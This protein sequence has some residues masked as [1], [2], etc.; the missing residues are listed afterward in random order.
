M[1]IKTANNIK[2]LQFNNLSKFKKI[3]HFSTTRIGGSSL[4]KLK[5]FNLGYTVND[6]PENVSKNLEQLAK[7]I[8]FGKKQMISPKQTHSA[9]IGIITSENDIFP[10]TDALITNIPNLCIYVRTADCVPVL[11][12]D[13]TRNV[14]S[15]IHSGWKGTI[16]E[17]SKRTIEI[18]RK[19]FGTNSKNIFA[20]IGPS[21][22]PKVYEVGP[23]VLEQFIKSF[24]NNFCTISIKGSEKGFLDLWKANKQIL[25]ESSIPE[26]QIEVA[27]LCTYSNPEMFYSARRDGIKTGRLASGIMLK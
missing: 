26:N 18:M 2:Y 16:Q 8:D 12:F 20:G 1:I 6:N 17:I 11:L 4:G 24:G 23:E 22:G 9:N 5:S 3:I 21:I 15:T 7:S 13:P 25:I 10:D 19:E 14:V 27:E